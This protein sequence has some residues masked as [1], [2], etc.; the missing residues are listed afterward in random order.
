MRGTLELRSCRHP[1]VAAKM[2]NAFVPNDTL[3][4]AGGVPNVLVV[5]GPNMGGKSTVLRQTCIAVVMAQ[6]G[7]R[8]NAALCRLTPVDRVFT[9]IGSHDVLLEGKST[10]FTELEETAAIIQ[11]GSRR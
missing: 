4:N 8:V 7:C 1:V 9:R 2:G 10:L 11:H 3:M 6:L 5:T